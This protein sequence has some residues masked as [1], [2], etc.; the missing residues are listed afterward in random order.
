MQGQPVI[1]TQKLSNLIA[2]MYYPLH[3]RL[4]ENRTCSV[5][6]KGG[7]GSL[8]TS[9]T[10][11]QIILGIMRDPNANALVLRKVGDTVRGSVMESL[12]W[13]IF[14]LD[15]SAYF[16]HTKSPAEIT[17]IPTGQKIIMK[18]LDKPVKLKS[19][20]LHQGYFKYLWFEE[21]AEFNNM[22]EIRNVQQ[23]VQRG[24]DVFFEFLTYNPPNDP[25]SWVNA[26]CKKPAPYRIVHHSSYLQVPPKWLGKKF[27][28]D[29]ETLRKNDPLKYDHEY[30][31]LSVGR[32]EQIVFHGKW[33][34]KE[35]ETPD[36]S[37]LYQSRFFYGADWGFA[38]DPT[39]FIRCFI[40]RE[41]AEMNLYIDYESGGV[42]VDMWELGTLL[43]VIPEARRWQ[44]YGDNSR[45]E[46]ISYMKNEGFIIDGAKKW[47]G[48]VEDG[49]EYI[50]TFS[51]IYVHPR[52]VE[53]IGELKKYSYKVDRNSQK[54]LPII[55]DQNN[56]YI[57]ALRYALD[58]Y[59]TGDVSILDAL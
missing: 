8:K 41:G 35:F 33:Q 43:S 30:L 4:R 20:N 32:A 37:E 18:G 56:H 10:A 49:I 51:N 19:I 5:W 2:E 52:C 34:E 55:I 44:I 48:S 31:G 24:N 17:Y 11:I 16:R 39:A 59:I 22:E 7:R 53:T 57:D 50:R 27:I 54:I 38:N 25:D 42:G 46:T 9:F 15:A 29:A 12:L 28:D 23:S 45:P 1:P 47:K 14:M 13:A 26:E 21:A 3:D 36:A 58:E 40:R 6:L